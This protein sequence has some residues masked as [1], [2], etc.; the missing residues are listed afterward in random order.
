MGDFLAATAAEELIIER[1]RKQAKLKNNASSNADLGDCI[2]NNEHKLSNRNANAFSLDDNAH[3]LYEGHRFA[4]FY[5]EG[6][7][8]SHDYS[9]EPILDPSKQGARAIVATLKRKGTVLLQDDITYNISAQEKQESLVIEWSGANDLITVNEEPTQEE[10]DK[11]VQ[12]RINNMEQLIKNGYTNLVLFNL[13]DLSLTP[14]YQRKD[15]RAQRNAA[16]I[17]NYFNK[18]LAEQS[19]LLKTKYKNQ[20]PPIDLSIFDVCS[21]LREVYDTPEKYGFDKSKL[22]TPYTETKEFKDN[23]NNANN[24]QNKTSPSEGYMFWDDVHP[25]ADMDSWLAVKSK[26][27]YDKKFQFQAPAHKISSIDQKND[28]DIKKRLDKLGLDLPKTPENRQLPKNIK[29]ILDIIF[30]EAKKMYLS[31]NTT[32]K[33]KGELLLKFVTDIDKKGNLDEIRDYISTFAHY[34][35]NMNII[36]SHKNPIS[37]FLFFKH[38]TRTE[39]NINTLIDAINRLIP[40]PIMKPE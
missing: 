29:K 28:D 15:E 5:C 22:T 10:A 20:K 25:T 36:K 40:E 26:E 33:Q 7:L 6:G 17:S 27:Q 1:A 34:D 13:P 23:Q 32:R 16:E 8:T 31:E 19:E 39:D 38:T 30:F 37:D 24:R 14:R 9:Q 21:L 12:E 18:R 35:E 11:A 4:R 3:V 2:I